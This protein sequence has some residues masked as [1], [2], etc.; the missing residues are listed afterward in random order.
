MEDRSTSGLTELFIA[1]G[2]VALRLWND[3]FVEERVWFGFGELL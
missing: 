2:V 3:A 1:L